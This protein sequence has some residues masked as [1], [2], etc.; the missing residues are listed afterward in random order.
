MLCCILCVPWFTLRLGLMLPLLSHWSRR[1]YARAA[2]QA[3]VAA[4]RG[5]AECFRFG[6]GTERDERRAFDLY[7]P[8]TEPPVTWQ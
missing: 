5:L 4:Q 3:H 7:A 6:L 8:Y 2:S 1:R